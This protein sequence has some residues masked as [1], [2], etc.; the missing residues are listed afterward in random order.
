LRKTDKAILFQC[1]VELPHAGEENT[2][3]FW[4]PKT[5]TTDY[6][7][8]KMKIREVLEHFPFVGAKV[9]GF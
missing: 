8:I 2:A 7:F 6:K 5:K 1:V 3:E 9:K 4:L